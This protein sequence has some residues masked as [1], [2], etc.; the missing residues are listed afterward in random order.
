MDARTGTVTVDHRNAI[1]LWPPIRFQNDDADCIW[2]DLERGLQNGIEKEKQSNV[3]IEACEGIVC[4]VFIIIIIII[5]VRQC[6][7]GLN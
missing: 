5:S 4:T 2:E 1:G 7:F 3:C 6:D